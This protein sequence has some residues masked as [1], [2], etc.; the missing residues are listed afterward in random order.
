MHFDEAT[1]QQ[2]KD[3]DGLHP[4][5][6]DCVNME[7]YVPDV[8]KDA[9]KRFISET[10]LDLIREGC[11]I[12][13][14]GACGSTYTALL[15]SKET[16]QSVSGKR[17]GVIDRFSLTSDSNVGMVAYVSTPSVSNERLISGDE[18]G[19]AS[20]E[21]YRFI[22]LSGYDDVMPVGMGS[23]NGMRTFSSAANI[24]IPNIDVDP[25]GRELP[26]INIVL[27]YVFRKARQNQRICQ[28]LA[29]KCRSL[30]RW[31]ILVT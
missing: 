18:L 25:M 29:V 4:T 6:V 31:N 15:Y 9:G 7:T 20:K 14:T 3:S 27:P 10:D 22:G 17:K 1:C 24:N 28:M 26:G 13:G 2:G 21:S 16:L 5:A 23:S 11:C 8:S 30:Q 19:S 12:L